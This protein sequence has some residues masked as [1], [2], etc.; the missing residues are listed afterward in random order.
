MKFFAIFTV[1]LG[2]TGLPLIIY[3][4]ITR[5][6]VRS[7]QTCMK[8][9]LHETFSPCTATLLAIMTFTYVNPLLSSE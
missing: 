4:Y 1:F 7:K 9:E 6:M 2:M 3:S 5:N 8:K